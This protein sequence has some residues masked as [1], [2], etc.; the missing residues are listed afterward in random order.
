MVFMLYQPKGVIPMAITQERLISLLS[1]V[2]ENLARLRILQAHA[3][4]ARDAI[5]EA[6]D[7]RFIRQIVEDLSLAIH[8]AGELPPDLLE[9]YITEQAHFKFNSQRNKHNADASRRYRLRKKARE[10]EA[11]DRIQLIEAGLISSRTSDRPA[12]TPRQSPASTAE[13][14][15]PISNSEPEIE[16]NIDM[17]Y[18]HQRLINLEAQLEDPLSFTDIRYTIFRDEMSIS[19]ERVHAKALD[20][21]VASG[22]TKPGQFPGEITIDPNW[23]INPA[24]NSGTKDTDQN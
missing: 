22:M 9:I 16:I 13:V 19:D 3:R 12:T 5:Y 6:N 7:P 23:S 1:V 8:Q 10:D 17:A 24:A 4:R 2:D 14:S 11:N 20:Q 21:I 15:S 18:M